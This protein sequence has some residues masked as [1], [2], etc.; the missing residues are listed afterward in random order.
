[1]VIIHGEYGDELNENIQLNLIKFWENFLKE[2]YPN[3]KNNNPNNGRYINGK[4]IEG[5]ILSVL[6][7]EKWLFL[8]ND[9]DDDLLIYTADFDENPSK[10]IIAN[11][12]NQEHIEKIKQEIENWWVRR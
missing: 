9:S 1:M 12:F 5:N 10:L 7:K 2:K 8:Q 3:F 11:L 6:Y 4:L